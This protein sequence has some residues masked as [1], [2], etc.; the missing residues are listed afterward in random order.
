M[1]P[2]AHLRRLQLRGRSRRGL[3]AFALSFLALATLPAARAQTPNTPEI[4]SQD[5]LFLKN[6]TSR[7]GKLIG[8]D[9]EFFRL[10]VKIFENQPSAT[11][12]IP[13]SEVVRIEFAE[14]PEREAFIAGATTPDI[15]AAARIWGSG[16]R[17]LS[18]P[19][20]PSAR[21]GLRYAELLL[22][23]GNPLYASRALELFSKIEAR[24]WS[25]EDRAAA[26]R[27]R[28]QAMIA[29]G[30]AAGAVE[31][32]M[33]LAE[34]AEDPALL[35]EA[36]FILAR[37]SEESL[38]TLVEENP[39]WQQDPR[40]RPEY[41]RLLNEALDLYLYSPLFFGSQI[42]ASARGLW[43]AS[44]LYQFANLPR[45]AIESARDILILYPD[46]PEAGLANTFLSG[47]P[48]ELTQYDNEKDARTVVD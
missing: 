9:E 2:P 23:S 5:V 24:A 21:V 12:S 41:F 48:E 14:D 46:T 18:Q 30:D 13:R 44:R 25:P 45:D 35:V 17:F 31:E 28:L 16:E 38:R 1:K 42:S 29:T 10:Q 47:L 32:A 34:Q 37:A 3:L 20:S 8:S 4:E 39:R 36:K 43:A 22:L 26:R 15:L 40:I 7:A 33:E 11:I 27:G 6:E 19:R